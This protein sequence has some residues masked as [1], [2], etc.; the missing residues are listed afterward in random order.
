MTTLFQTAQVGVASDPLGRVIRIDGNSIG[1]SFASSTTN[2]FNVTIL[3]PRG[4][5]TTNSTVVVSLFAYALNLSINTYFT[6][7][8][9][10]VS[11]IGCDNVEQA[12]IAY[13]HV[14][15]TCGF[16]GGLNTMCT[17]CNGQVYDNVSVVPTFDVCNVCSGQVE[18]GRGTTC[19]G[20]DGVA[21]SRYQWDFCGNCVLF[22]SDNCGNHYS[23]LAIAGIVIF[24]ASF[25]L[26]IP[27]VLIAYLWWYKLKRLEA[28]LKKNALFRECKIRVKDAKSR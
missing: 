16:C 14:T 15:D 5:P 4:Q 1:Q 24:I 27:M 28:K 25:L 10:C 17:G 23:A 7:A 26:I 21:F 13:R 2:S 22:P 8:C 20:C 11:C 18:V 19:A 9:T 6:P 12:N 3:S